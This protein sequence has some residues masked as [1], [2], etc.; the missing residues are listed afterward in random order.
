M[1]ITSLSAI[2]ASGLSANQARLDTSAH[3]I[4][5]LDTEG[6]RRQ[7]VDQQTQANGSVSTRLHQTEQPG[8]NLAQDLVNQQVALY[9][10]K[11]NIQ[12]LKTGDQVLGSLLDVAA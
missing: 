1:S 8:D 3:N 5:N 6:F 4:A 10:F 12:V 2:A 11:A 9:N 7:A